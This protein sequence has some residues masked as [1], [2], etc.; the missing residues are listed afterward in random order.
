[1]KV[2]VAKPYYSNL[3]NNSSWSNARILPDGWDFEW[4]TVNVG[5]KGEFAHTYIEMTDANWDFG[6]YVKVTG[7]LNATDLGN[8]KNLTNLMKLDLSEAEFT[9]L[10]SS[11]LS[12]KTSLI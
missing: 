10:P 7:A 3:R 4:M 5:R 11:F 8:I 9:E 12:N 2:Y 6:M 1:M